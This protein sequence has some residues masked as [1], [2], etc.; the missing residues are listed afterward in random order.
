MD[1]FLVSDKVLFAKEP[2]SSVLNEARPLLELHFKEIAS[3]KDILVSPN[4]SLEMYKRGEEEGKLLLITARSQQRLVGYF[5]WVMIKH[6]HYQ[7][8]IVAEEDL[9]FLLPEY[10]RGMTG[11]LF[12]KFA[13][14]AALDFGAHMLVSREKIGHEHPAL[15]ERLGFKATDVV[16]YKMKDK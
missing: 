10:R 4:P 15:M 9:H 3:N 12:I 11:Y 6:P 13:C 7:H 2:F 5:L 16:Y 1:Q 8:V 14:Q